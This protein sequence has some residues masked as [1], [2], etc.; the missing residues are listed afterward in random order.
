MV[1]HQRMMGRKHWVTTN[2]FRLGNWH[3]TPA[4]ILDRLLI[5]PAGIL[6][7]P[8]RKIGAV[9]WNVVVTRCVGSVVWSPHRRSTSVSIVSLY[10]YIKYN[11][12]NITSN[13]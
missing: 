2:E 7:S 13:A 11:T 5:F 8:G 12:R 9:H 1:V 6:H 10:V 4:K 3:A